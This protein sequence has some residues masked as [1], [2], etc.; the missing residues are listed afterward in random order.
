MSKTPKV[1]SIPT[2]YRG[3]QYRSQLEAKWACVF[4]L[5]GIHYEYEPIALKGYVPDYLAD[6][7]LYPGQGARS[8]RPLLIEVR[9]HWDEE[10]YAESIAKIARSGWTGAAMILGCTIRSK[11]LFQSQPM[12]WFGMA[13]PAVVPGHANAETREWF[14]VGWQDTGPAA[15]TFAHGATGDITE[16]W[17]TAQSAVR[18]MPPSA[19]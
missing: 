13:H 16:H 3:T 15:G 2:I 8:T 19:R 5:L 6:C 1:H 4:D 7:S 12:Q 18:W 17:K 14:T 9:P 11:T 10:E